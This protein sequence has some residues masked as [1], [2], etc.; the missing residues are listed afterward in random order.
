MSRDAGGR[1]CLDARS[2]QAALGVAPE[3]PA[4][5]GA[6]LMRCPECDSTQ[7]FF[8]IGRVGT[9]MVCMSCH[10]RWER[11]DPQQEPETSLGPRFPAPDTL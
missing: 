1:T 3:V 6:A 4:E 5:G 7:I 11:A 10:A 9:S 2:S 8:Y